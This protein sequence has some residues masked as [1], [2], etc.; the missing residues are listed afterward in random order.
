M[1]VIRSDSKTITVSWTPL[2]FTEARG[3]IIGYQITYSTISRRR[4]S[5]DEK[6]VVVNDG[7]AHIFAISDLDPAKKY[8]VT[9]AGK[10]SQGFGILSK[11][12]YEGG[13]F[14]LIISEVAVIICN[15]YNSRS[16]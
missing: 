6:T 11:I 15:N 2:N 3:F 7:N 16:K 9:I 13:N 12:S 14:S 4:R 5:T 1:N 10:T 8:G